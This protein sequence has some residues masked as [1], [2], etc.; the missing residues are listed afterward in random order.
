MLWLPFWC[1]DCDP[2]TE[3]MYWQY[4]SEYCCLPLCLIKLDLDQLSNPFSNIYIFRS[5]SLLM[6]IPYTAVR[7]KNLHWVLY[8]L[9]F[10]FSEHDQDRGRQVWNNP[11]G[12]LQKGMWWISKE[13]WWISKEMWWLRKGMGW[14]SKEMWWI[15]K[16]MWWISEEMWWQRKEMWLP[17]KEIL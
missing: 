1:D 11:F 2:F 9:L 10:I 17:S 16:D 4:S 14:I 7:G 13:M 8:N 5:L 12:L 6:F 15:S 3:C